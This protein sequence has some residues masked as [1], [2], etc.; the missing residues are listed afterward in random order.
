MCAVICLS[1]AGCRVSER[2]TA[3]GDIETTKTMV[4]QAKANPGLFFSDAEKEMWNESEVEGVSADGLPLVSL[5][6]VKRFKNKYLNKR[7]EMSCYYAMHFPD[8]PFLCVNPWHKTQETLTITNIKWCEHFKNGESRT[9]FDFGTS[10]VRA[11]GTLKRGRYFCPVHNYWDENKLFFE[12]ESMT[13]KD[14][15]EEVRVDR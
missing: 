3:A 7:I 11:V 14:S 1:G 9:D 5:M 13:Y 6:R 2:Q 10:W 12:L 15:W 8:G 4:S